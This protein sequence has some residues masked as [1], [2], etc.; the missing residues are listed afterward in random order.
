MSAYGFACTITS[1]ISTAMNP[2]PEDEVD[3]ADKK[4]Q[5]KRERV[6]EKRKGRR[7]GETGVA[8]KKKK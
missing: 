1:Q 3:A 8:G 6:A 2:Q 5:E 4:R 7:T